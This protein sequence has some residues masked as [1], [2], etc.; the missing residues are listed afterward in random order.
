MTQIEEIA[1]GREIYKTFKN[2]LV[3]SDNILEALNDCSFETY[4]W[5]ED[6]AHNG[7]ATTYNI[8]LVG[9]NAT[10]N[11]MVD[12]Y[13]DDGAMHLDEQF[14]LVSRESDDWDGLYYGLD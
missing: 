7:T 10:I 9:D 4:I 1:Y 8:N 2:I 6:K 5:T 12:V 11:V 14:E 13:H 3:E